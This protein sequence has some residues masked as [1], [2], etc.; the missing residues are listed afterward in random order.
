MT[1]PGSRSVELWVT[2]VDVGPGHVCTLATGREVRELASAH[3]SP[4]FIPGPDG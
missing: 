4:G 2:D 3:L 1:L